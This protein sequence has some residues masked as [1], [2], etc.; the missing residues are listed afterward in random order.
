[1]Q[2]SMDF[3]GCFVNGYTLKN[4]NVSDFLEEFFVLYEEF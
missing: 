3:S 2:I 4:C 1:M